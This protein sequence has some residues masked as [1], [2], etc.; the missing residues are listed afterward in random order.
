MAT[1]DEKQLQATGDAEAIEHFKRAVA[2]GKHWYPALLEAMALWASAEE[3]YKGRHYRYLIDG[4]AF[5]WLLLAERLCQEVDGLLPEQEMLGLLFQGKPP[6]EHSEE[7]F[8]KLIG[9]V[10]YRAYL[11]YFYGVIVEQALL[12]AVD[13]EI[14]KERRAHV[15]QDGIPDTYQRVYGASQ[16]TLLRHFRREKGY[17]RRS[18]IALSELPEFTYWLFKYRLRNS[19]KARVASDTKKALVHLERLRVAKGFPPSSGEGAAEVINYKVGG[20]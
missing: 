17:P 8:K 18:D 5:N 14:D 11:N 1:G 4:Q 2:L 3:D 10:K 12:L 13:K 9:S 16:Q 15:Q 7:E 19:D 20:G 6:I